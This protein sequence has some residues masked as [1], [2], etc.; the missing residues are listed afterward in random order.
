MVNGWLFE[1][2]C[3]S[4]ASCI[5]CAILYDISPSDWC[6]HDDF[7]LLFS[8]SVV[9]DSLQPCELQHARLPF[10]H[11]LLELAQIHVHW[12]GDAIQPYHPL[13]SP[14]SSCL[15]SFPARWSFLMRPLFTSGSQSIGF[16]HQSFQ[17][18]FRVDFPSDWLEY[19]MFLFV[20]IGLRSFHALTRI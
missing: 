9:S 15:R 11:H 16:Q 4:F 20:N 2:G 13:T 17:C 3:I 19:S 14:F 6:C 12:V 8:C 18:I 10:L 5:L 7:K 1:Q